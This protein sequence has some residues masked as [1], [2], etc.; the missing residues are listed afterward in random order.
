MRSRSMRRG[1]LAMVVA[2]TCTAQVVRAQDAV[3]AQEVEARP[4]VQEQVLLRGRNRAMLHPSDPLSIG[5]REQ[6]EN[7]MRAGTSALQR[8]KTATGGVS[9]D[10]NYRRAIAMVESRAKFSVPPTRVAL[11][12]EVGD[13]VVARDTKSPART[14]TATTTTVPA[15]SNMPWAIGGVIAGALAIASWFCVRNR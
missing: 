2:I 1:M 13:A 7:Q 10:D 15:S 8:G 3:P 6:G 14:G 4:T 12:S 11:E 5:G 9:G